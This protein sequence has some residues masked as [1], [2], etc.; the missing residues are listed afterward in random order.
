MELRSYVISHVLRL[1]QTSSSALKA[2]LRIFRQDSKTL[3]SQSSALSFKAKVDLLHDLDELESTEYSHLIKL[4]EIRNQFAHNHKATSF[5]AFDDINKDINKYL[6]KHCPTEFVE[7]TN[8]EKKLFSVFNHLFTVAAGR[9]LTIEIEYSSGIKKEMRKHI[10]DIVVEN[11]DTIWENALSKN[12]NKMASIPGL[13]LMLNKQT[14]VDFFYDDF[15]HAMSEFTL[16]ELK[17]LEGKETSI[18]RQK[19]TIDDKLARMEKPKKKE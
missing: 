8:I 9:L 10:N 1:E 16:G 18:F 17:K 14:D 12:K 3:G 13:E 19:E 15:K 5:Q 6:L 11:L 7:E 4:M 2:V